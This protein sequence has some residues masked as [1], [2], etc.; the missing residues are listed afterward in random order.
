MA[1]NPVRV[2]Q[3]HVFDVRMEDAVDNLRRKKTRQPV[4]C[5]RCKKFTTDPD[6]SCKEV[7]NAAYSGR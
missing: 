1:T 6:E 2:K 5:L 3:K 4:R 7:N